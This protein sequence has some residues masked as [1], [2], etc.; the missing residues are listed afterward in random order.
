MAISMAVSSVVAEDGAAEVEHG[1]SIFMVALGL[2]Y[3]RCRASINYSN[4]ARYLSSM[5]HFIHSTL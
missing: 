4:K 3:N 5:L 2:L 1:W